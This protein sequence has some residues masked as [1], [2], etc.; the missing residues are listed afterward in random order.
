MF[1]AQVVRRAVPRTYTIEHLLLAI[2][3]LSLGW[4]AF[5]SISSAH[6][7]AALA[8]ELEQMHVKS[9]ASP[10]EPA[11]RALR[12]R[13]APRSVIGRIDVPRLKLT[14]LAREGADIQT[15]R[16]SIGHVPDTALPDDIGNAT[17][18][19]HRDTVFRS[20]GGVQKGDEIVVTTA[21]GMYQYI[22]TATLIVA[23]TETSILAPTKGHS[24]TLVTCYPFDY[25]GAAP[26]RFI[27][28]AERVEST[29]S[30]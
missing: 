30:E 26:E 4:Y 10:V 5:V 16:A 6:E 28:R 27:V 12:A 2:A 20:L 8:S 23:P 24:L 7:Q 25:I 21:S 17:F 1:R 15:L 14:A 3:V 13:L 22:V 29:R 9:S 11:A 18:A 19:G